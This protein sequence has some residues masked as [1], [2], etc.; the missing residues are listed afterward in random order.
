M[1]GPIDSAHILRDIADGA[2]T[3]TASEIAIDFIAND[4]GDFKA[5]FHVSALDTAEAN[6]TYSLAIEVDAA[7][8]FSSPVEIGS[9]TVTA[10]GVYELP[11]SGRFIE[12]A[13][14][15]AL[16]MRAT[17]TLGGTTP[18]ITYGAFLTPAT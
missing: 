1:Y 18:S 13:E 2:E 10:A 9:I 12:Q 7:A 8:G 5:V 17:A 6:E 11:L 14:A 16:K 4:F 15:G 3:A